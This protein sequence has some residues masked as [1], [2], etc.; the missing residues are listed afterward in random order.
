MYRILTC[1]VQDISDA[2]KILYMHYACILLQKWPLLSA[3]CIY[4]LDKWINMMFIKFFKAF[5]DF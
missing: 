3:L 4:S 1:T 5:T 2:L